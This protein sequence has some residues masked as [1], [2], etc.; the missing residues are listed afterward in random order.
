MISLRQAEFDSLRAEKEERIGQIIRVRKQERDMKR[1]RKY[2]LK[3][4]EERIGKLQEEE[5]APKPEGKPSF[6]EY[7]T[8]FAVPI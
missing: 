8:T 2:Y 5:E 7:A 1:K 6:D 4:E 3:S